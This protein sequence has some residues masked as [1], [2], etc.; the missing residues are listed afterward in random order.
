MTLALSVMSSR[1]LIAGTVAIALLQT[2]ALAKMVSDR[3][4]LLRD[5]AEVVLETGAIDP[6]DLFRGHYATLNLEI[7]RVP[8]DSVTVDPALMPGMPVYMTLSEGPEGYWRAAGLFATVPNSPTPVIRGM[9]EYESDRELVLGFPFNRYFAPEERALKLEAFD[10]A[11]RIGVILALD[12]TG[13][14]AIKGLMIDGELVYE[15]PLF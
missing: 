9:F 6:R 5:G 8:R 11:N 2:A 1:W 7:S 4:A 14:G 3:A 10:R 12:G 13:Y 15:E